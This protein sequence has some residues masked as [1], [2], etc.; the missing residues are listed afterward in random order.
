MKPLFTKLVPLFLAGGALAP[1]TGAADNGK[2]HIW[3]DQKSGI[4]FVRIDKACFQMGNDATVHPLADGGWVRLNYTQSLSADEGPAHEACLDGYWLGR[5]E[6]TRKQWQRVMGSLP[7][8]DATKTGTV[9]VTRVTWEQANAFT[10][11]LGALHGRRYRFRLP[12]EAEWE[13]ACR[14]GKPG[15]MDQG[16][17]KNEAELAEVAVADIQA[18]VSPAEVGSRKPNAADFFDLLGNVW[19]WTADDYAA[20][21]YARHALYNPR[22]KSGG[23]VAVIRGGSLRTEFVQVRCTMRGRYPKQDT[24]DLIGL[25][26]VRED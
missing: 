21:G 1:V 26:V 2:P 5:H 25:R 4:E 11:R 23:D 9:P 6:I 20:D 10:E 13:F 15:A 18:P 17:P 12:T 19:E 3:L 14:G 7:D 8:G 22:H 24:L 16:T